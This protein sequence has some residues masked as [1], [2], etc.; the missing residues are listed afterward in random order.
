MGYTGH[1]MDEVPFTQRVGVAV[2]DDLANWDKLP[3]NPTTEAAAPLYEPVSSGHRTAS[4]WRDPFLFDTG[5]EV[6]QYVC[7]RRTDGDVSDRGTLGL[8]RTRDM[9]TWE[10]MPPPDHDRVADELE[11]PQV[12]RIDSLYYL[13]FCTHPKWLAPAFRERFPGH[14]FR[15]TDYSMVGESPLGPFRV[16]GTGEITPAPPDYH[17]YAGQ[18]VHWGGDWF[19]LGTARDDSG[20]WLTDPKPVRADDTGVHA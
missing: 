17:Q 6:I 3:E 11:V 15:S 8:A 19:L 5:E 12:H 9:R 14:A 1:K 7:A 13:V 18:L 20:W 16:H 2:S 10:L 4:I